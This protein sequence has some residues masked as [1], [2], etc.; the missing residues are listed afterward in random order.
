M[1]FMVLAKPGCLLLDALG[2][3][4]RL[5]AVARDHGCGCKDCLETI[6]LDFTNL[7]NAC[8]LAGVGAVTVIDALGGRWES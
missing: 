7:T 6:A 4:C 8:F 1:P 2:T 3:A 5:E